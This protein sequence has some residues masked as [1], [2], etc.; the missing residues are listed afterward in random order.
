M[1]PSFKFGIPQLKHARF[2]LYVRINIFIR[3]DPFLPPP[4]TAISEE[5]VRE[6]HENTQRAGPSGAAPKTVKETTPNP[7]TNNPVKKPQTLEERINESKMA[8]FLK[9]EP[10]RE[11][12]IKPTTVVGV[13]Q[14]SSR[15]EL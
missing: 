2:N 4:T 15:E 13:G 8:R 10:H 5:N 9:D 14:Q 1:D 6:G 3:D 12:P 11:T 7:K